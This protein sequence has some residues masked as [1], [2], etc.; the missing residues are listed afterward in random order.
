MSQKPLSDLR[1][2]L[3][4]RSDSPLRRWLLPLTVVV[5]G[6]VAAWLMYE[7]GR[8][9]A[10]F[11]GRA[12]ASERAILATQRDAQERQLRELRVQLA[13]GEETRLAQVRERS[14]VARSIGELQAQ[15]ARAQQDLQ[16]YQA[17]ANPRAASGA[18]VAVKQFTVVTRG[19]DMRHFLLRFALARESRQELTVSGQVLLTVD[20]ERAGSAASVDLA[21]ISDSR[22]KQ[23]TFSFR[24]FASIEHPITLP[25]DFKPARVTIEVKLRDGTAVPYRKTFVWNPGN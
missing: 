22:A 18:A 16:F 8:M 1:R 10:G 5:M 12:A 3:V 17:I 2:R 13:A 24:Y 20:G 9:V 14:E 23:L 7:Y 6:V 25:E 4:I 19:T 21:A 15:L 11:D